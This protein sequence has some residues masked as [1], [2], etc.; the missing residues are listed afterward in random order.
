MYLSIFGIITMLFQPS[1]EKVIDEDG[2]ESFEGGVDGNPLTLAYSVMLSLWSVM[3]LSAWKRRGKEHAYLWGSEGAEESEQPRPAFEGVVEVNKETGREELVHGPAPARVAKKVFST[4]IIIGCMIA[5]AVCAFLAT[6]LK[7]RAPDPDDPDVG[8]WDKQKWGLLSSVLNLVIIISFGLMYESIALKLNDFENYRTETE[9]Q[10]GLISKNF[11]FQFVN[12]Y[13]ILFFIA[14]LQQVEIEGLRSN[15]CEQS[16]LP[17]L[18]AQMM[19]V[20][21]GK[22]FATQ[23]VE[24]FK[25]FLMKKIAMLFE[26]LRLKKLWNTVTEPIVA[27]AHKIDG[28]MHEEALDGEKPEPEDADREAALAARD[29][30]S[31]KDISD[32]FEKQ[33]HFQDYEK[34]GTFDDFNE[35]AIQ[36]GYVALFSPAFPLAPFFAAINNVVEIR[37]DAYA[38]CGAYKRPIWKTRYDNAQCTLYH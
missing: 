7:F 33:T 3:F 20:F 30:V 16:C 9:Y 5:T 4:T 10:D 36:Y 25:P 19:V 12:N 14:Y 24:I 8:L 26:V 29:K 6:T 35:M 27:G 31:I 2:N 37:G 11:L 13:F 28:M 32:H 34:K 22:T 38:L 1:R 17:V 23:I 21:T 18:Q 15:K